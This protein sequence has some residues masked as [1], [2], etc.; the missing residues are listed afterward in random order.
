MKKTTVESAVSVYDYMIHIRR[1]I[2]RHPELSMEEFQTQK[3][4]M[5]ELKG[6]GL[7]P[8]PCGGTGVIC[9]IRGSSG[10]SD[11]IIALRADM[12]ALRVQELNDVP[13]KSEIDG[14]MHAC[15]HDGHVASLLGAAKVL[16]EQRDNFKG[17]VRLCFQPGEEPSQ[18]AKAMIADG[19]LKDVDATLGIHLWTGIPSGKI[20]VDAGNRM[21]AVNQFAYRIIGK[22]GHGGLP[23]QGIDA[24]LATCAIIQNLQSVVSREYS[25]LEPV[26]L[27]IGKCEFGTQ[28]NVIAAESTFEGSARWFSKETQKTIQETINRIVFETAQTFRCQV[29]VLKPGMPPNSTACINPRQAAD[30]AA[31][32]VRTLFGKEAL[33]PFP[34]NTAS[35]DYCF[36]MDEVPDSLLCFVG[37]G[38][39]DKGSHIPHHAGNFNIDE[40][41]LVTSAAMYAQYAMDFLNE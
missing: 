36:F 35:E 20:S 14:L 27:T 5:D 18:G 29:E 38:N 28:F 24:G 19:A 8:L 32:S 39:P 21:A 41:S 26:V 2:H 13:Y 37:T 30:R 33:Y 40:D 17:T 3:L 1:T 22:P 12:D 9:D 6:L 34:T 4:I 10:A 23:Q 25:P 7:N 15:G 11:K 16:L 31:G